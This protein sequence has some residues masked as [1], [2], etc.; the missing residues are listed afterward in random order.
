MILSLLLL[1]CGGSS[2]SV[3]IETG[4]HSEAPIP[5]QLAG[6]VDSQIRRPTERCYKEALKEESDL[7]GTVTY[8]VYGS[9]GVL[10]P[11]LTSSG[12]QALLDCA[13]E[14]MQNQRLLRVLGDGDHFVGF[15]VRVEFN[16]G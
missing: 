15:T 5:P 13:L 7:E 3:T 6:E 1:A 9:H 11:S 12:P 8:E 14:P 16:R 2:P 4:A 10:I